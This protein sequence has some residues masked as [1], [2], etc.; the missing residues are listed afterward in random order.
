AMANAYLE[1]Q[2]LK[3][4]RFR[5]NF[6]YRFNA[7]SY[8]AYTPTFHL[9]TTSINDIDDI[10]QNQ[11]VGYGWLLENTLAYRRVFGAGHEFDAVDGQSIEQWGLGE[12]LNVTNSN[13]SFPGSWKHAYVGNRTPF[14][15]FTPA[16]SGGLIGNNGH[17]VINKY[18]AFFGRLN[19][20]YKET[21][22]ASIVMRADASSNFNRSHRWGYFPSV[23]A[24]WN[25]TN[26]S[27]ME[28]TSNWLNYLKLR[29]SWGQNGNANIDPLQ[30]LAT[31]STDPKNGYYFG[32]DKNTLL[33]GA[34]PD[35]LPNELV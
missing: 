26:E 23:S 29:A 9:S 2:P 24:G 5:S 16:I 28:G 33:N 13:S 11:S 8:R 20:N 19:Y 21:Y 1:I 15:G 18:A 31:I 14:T 34:Y 22:M 32:N 3:D 12:N 17:R 30:F 35:I 4:L 27:F 6:G 7:S 25:I 10:S